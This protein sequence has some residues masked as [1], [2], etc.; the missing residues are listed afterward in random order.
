[1]QYT[2]VYVKELEQ[3]YIQGKHRHVY[4]QSGFM[5]KVLGRIL[6]TKKSG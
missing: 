2:T 4:V 1:M 6:I 5:A 3:T